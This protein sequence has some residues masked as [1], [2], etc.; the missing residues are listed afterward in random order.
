VEGESSLQTLAEV[1]IALA[2][3]ASLLVVLRR[4]GSASLS[5]GE[6]ADLFVVVGGSLMVLLFSLLPLPLG[7][8]GLS[9]PLLWGIS[10]ALLSIGLALGYLAI[11]RQRSRLLAA[12]VQPLFPRLSGFA[13]HA[14]LPVVAL[15]ILNATGMLLGRGPGLYI[16][17]L[18]LVLALSA[19]PL[20]F[21][22]VELAGGSRE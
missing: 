20:L 22:V 14:P 11:L 2:G 9:G 15:L 5:E 16:L 18:I 12:G 19:L 7:H 21:V 8:L 10:S 4:G 13:V 17:S 6:G 1:S 3:F